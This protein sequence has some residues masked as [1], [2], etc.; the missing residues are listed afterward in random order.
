MGTNQIL[1]KNLVFLNGLWRKRL[2]HLI[3]V[4]ENVKV[5]NSSNAI[6]PVDFNAGCAR[7]H[8]RAVI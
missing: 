8:A 5:D 2:G 1:C 7:V 3:K 6:R 4:I